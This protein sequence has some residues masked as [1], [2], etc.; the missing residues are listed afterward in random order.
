MKLFD[1]HCHI[2]DKAYAKDLE[3]VL[4]RARKAGVARMMCAGVTLKTSKKAIALAESYSGVV[5]AV[6]IHPHDVR[7]CTEE[8]L[9]SLVELSRKPQVCAWGEIGL[10]FNR[11]YSPRKDQEHWFTRQL[12]T[13]ADLDLPMIFHERDSGGRFL[14]ILKTHAP[15]NRRGVVHCFS[16]T[17]AE[18]EHYI[19]MGLFIGITG[20]VTMPGRGGE[21]RRMIP[22][23][24]IDRL[25]VE[26]DAPYL[27]PVPDKRDHRRNEPAFVR[28]VMLKLAEV[29]G[30]D[31]D[32][33]AAQIWQNTC[34][35]YGLEQ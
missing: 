24:P 26:T 8:G 32:M 1:S 17:E 18:L 11:M 6:G 34:R 3:A 25:L 2:D 5:A 23:I 35:I 12:E 9:R 19:E 33:L 31:P 13:V 28:S 29:L 15:E 30:E 20:I 7:N 21:L 4:E 27:T 22:R 14:E 16:G 10:D